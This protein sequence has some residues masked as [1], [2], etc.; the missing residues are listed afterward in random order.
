MEGVKIIPA[1]LGTNA[2]AVGAVAFVLKKKGLLKK[3]DFFDQSMI[4]FFQA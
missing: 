2:G 4:G 3:G 1:T